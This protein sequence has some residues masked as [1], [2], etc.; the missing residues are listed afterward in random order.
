MKWILRN[1]MRGC[2]LGS[3][4]QEQGSLV[5]SE[6]SNEPLGSIKDEEFVIS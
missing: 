6:C 2:G 5:S 4:S 1:R 3:F